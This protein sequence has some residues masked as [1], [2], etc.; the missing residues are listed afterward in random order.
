MSSINIYLRLPL[1]KLKPAKKIDIPP[2]NR[3]NM[4]DEVCFFS[5][6]CLLCFYEQSRENVGI[7][8]ND[9]VG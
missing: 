7:A 3:R 1:L 9:A 4:F 2:G 6:S 8:E 5:S